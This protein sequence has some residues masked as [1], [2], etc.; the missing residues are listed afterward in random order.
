MVNE[1][2]AIALLALH[3]HN[4]MKSRVNEKETSMGVALP[5]AKD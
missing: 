1:R 3:A 5:S 4:I 2:A